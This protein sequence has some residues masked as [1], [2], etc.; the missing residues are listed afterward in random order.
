[1][2]K[3]ARRVLLL[4]ACFGLVLG[5][6]MGEASLCCPCGPETGEA[7]A[8][9]AALGAEEAPSAEPCGDEA[10]AAD[11]VDDCGADD[12]GADDGLSCCVCCHVFA[13]APAVISGPRLGAGAAERFLRVGA[14]APPPRDPEGPLQVP[15]GV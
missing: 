12:C 3:L 11:G 13:A 1:M 4:F 8:A 9:R 5:L 15:I 2:L 6:P 14:R 7:P 10:A